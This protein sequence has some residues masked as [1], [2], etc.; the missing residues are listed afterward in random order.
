VK[1]LGTAAGAA[2][3]A[4]TAFVSRGM[5]FVAI[6]LAGAAAGAEATE[7]FKGAPTAMAQSCPG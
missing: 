2:A 3:V 6:T 1:K 7:P 4:T 5:L